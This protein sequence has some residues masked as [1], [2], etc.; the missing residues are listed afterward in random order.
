M[1]K[2]H[3]HYQ[4][5]FRSD[6]SDVD[7][8]DQDDFSDFMNSMAGDAKAYWEAQKDYYALV[9]SERGAKLSADLIGGTVLCACAAFVMLFLSLGAAIWLGKVVED[10]ALGFVMVGGIYL[11]LSVVLI[12]VW[13][14]RY[15]DDTIVRIV[16]S[17]YNGQ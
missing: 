10:V 2:T 8:F 16:N 3:H 13:R 6:A 9:A 5:P 1:S 12:I 17:L 15:R 7:P 11:L 14:S 4:E